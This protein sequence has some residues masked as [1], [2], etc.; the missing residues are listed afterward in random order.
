MSADTTVATKSLPVQNGRLDRFIAKY[1]QLSAA[2]AA[3][4]ALGVQHKRGTISAFDPAFPFYTQQNNELQE[5]AAILR[6][7]EEANS[8]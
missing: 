2:Q 1:G 6:K 5:Y 4:L 7:Q 3:E 8:S